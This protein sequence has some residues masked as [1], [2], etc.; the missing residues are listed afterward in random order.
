[1]RGNTNSVNKLTRKIVV[2]KQ[3]FNLHLLSNLNQ[4]QLGV[5]IIKEICYSEV[6]PILQVTDIIPNTQVLSGIT[7]SLSFP[8]AS[9]GFIVIV[10]LAK[11]IISSTA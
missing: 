1:M 9:G 3:F 8:V 4:L 2:G 6:L 11:A 7:S 10:K 5:Y